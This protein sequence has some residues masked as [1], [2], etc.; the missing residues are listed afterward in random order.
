MRKGAGDG[1]NPKPQPPFYHYLVKHP[2]NTFLPLL[3]I[4][5]N[6]KLEMKLCKNIAVFYFTLVHLSGALLTLKGFPVS[7]SVLFEETTSHSRF[8]LLEGS[9]NSAILWH[10]VHGRTAFSWE[11]LKTHDCT[12]FRTA[13][14]LYCYGHTGSQR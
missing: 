9:T 10:T 7:V 13:K 5:F 8:Y 3:S 11:H 12:E 14:L 1:Q 4:L 6:H 2:L